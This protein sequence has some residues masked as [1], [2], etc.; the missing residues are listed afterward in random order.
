MADY[1]GIT[2]GGGGGSGG[3]DTN[4]HTIWLEKNAPSTYST[5]GI[6]VD[7]SSTFSSLGSFD[8]QI[9]KATRGNIPFGR[10]EKSISGSTLTFKILGERY[11]RVTGVGNVANQPSG[12]TV[13]STSGQTSVSESSHVHSIE[14]D[15]GAANS[16]GP[17]NSG[18]QVLL[19]ALGPN[20]S[21]HTHSVNIPNFIGNSGAG[22]S[23]NHTD[24][25]IYSHSHT[26]THTAT[27]F[28]ITELA[29]GTS[30]SG[31]EFSIRATGQ[32]A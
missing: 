16:S 30:L 19:D 14:H 26:E 4:V 12:V 9:L 31:V 29:N 28:S 10:F 27:N 25:T 18:T 21:T 8:V 32:R 24:N 22:T 7:L 6:S 17:S 2:G 5:G 1:Y 23:H 11:E 3:D 15:H 20:L 13:Q